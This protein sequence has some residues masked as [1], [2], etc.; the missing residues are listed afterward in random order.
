M[1]VVL[2]FTGRRYWRGDYA[3]ILCTGRGVVVWLG[4]LG[5]IGGF[6]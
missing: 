3:M 1:L 4:Y 5:G 6:S 2:Q